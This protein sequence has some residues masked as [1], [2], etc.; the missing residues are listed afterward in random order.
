MIEAKLYNVYGWWR[1]Y[2]TADGRTFSVRDGQHYF[3]HGNVK[4]GNNKNFCAYIKNPEK[5]LARVQF[6][7]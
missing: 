6:V 3:Y 1:Y 5:L 7:K 4:T 2:R